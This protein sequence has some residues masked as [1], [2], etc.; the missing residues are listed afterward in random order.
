[1]HN[2]APATPVQK[3]LLWALLGLL[4]LIWFGGLEYRVLFHPDEGRYAEIP[5]EMVVRGDWITPHLN[6]LP[7]FEKPPLQYW[8]TAAAFE[9]FGQH[10]WT[11]RLYP[12][13]TGLLG[14]L[15]TALAGWRLFGRE[16]GLTAAAILGSSFL[17]VLG[18]QV[19]T[20]DMGLSF[21]LHLALVGFLWAQRAGASERET[22]HGMWLAWAAMALAVLSKGLISIVLP[23][24]ALGVYIAWQRDWH[25]LRRLHLGGGL[26]LFQLIAAPWFIAVSARNPTFPDFFFIR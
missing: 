10:Q 4:A 23:A 25:L 5:R 11:V 15:L 14:V 8:A 9:V 16:T 6:D 19:I 17:Y 24:L 12:A 3:A 1:M 18:G 13:L 20:L 2:P 22:R 21:V 26:T 7:Y